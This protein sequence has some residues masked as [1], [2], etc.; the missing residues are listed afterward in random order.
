MHVY[1]TGQ[2]VLL[3]FFYSFCGWVWECCYVSACQKRWVNRGFL[4]GPVLPI[5]GSGAILILLATIPVA[6]NLWLVYFCG[7]AAATLLEYVTGWAMERLFR[8]RYWDYSKQR[9]NCRGYICLSSSIAW[10]FFSILLIRV[11]HPPI[12]SLIEDVPGFL[13][14]PL[15]L[16]LTALFTVDAV[17]SAE[18]ALD[19]GEML[20]KLEE[21]NEDLRRLAKRAEVAAAFAKDDLRRFR[22]RTEVEKLL[23]RQRIEE[24][25]EEQRQAKAARK[26]RRRE[27]IEAALGRRTAAKLEALN[28]IAEALETCRNHVEDLPDLTKEAMEARR[29]DLSEA[30]E[31]VRDREAMLRARSSGAYHRSLRIL[32]NHPTATAKGHDQ[33]L[34]TLRD[35]EDRDG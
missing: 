13:V 5:Y 28:A 4:Q 33:A 1:T 26:L 18:A 2:W 19:L 15:A 25:I 17:R 10:G 32:R 31:R 34:R 9:F 20:A 30:L 35:L 14:D 11:V 24:G 22:E 3:F 16:V 6:E 27:R 29:A 7:T 8:V 21:E 12:S 23:V